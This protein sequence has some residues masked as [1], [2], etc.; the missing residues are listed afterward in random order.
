MSPPCLFLITS[1]PG[2]TA[3]QLWRSCRCLLLLGVFGGSVWVT[4]LVERSS[5]S[6]SYPLM[7]WQAPLLYPL[8]IIMGIQAFPLCL[9]IFQGFWGIPFLF[10]LLHLYF[11][12]LMSGSYP[13]VLQVSSFCSDILFLAVTFIDAVVA[14]RVIQ[15]ILIGGVTLM[16]VTTFQSLSFFS[17]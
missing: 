7:S 16:R 3:I 9:L 2:R 10:L 6:A 12:W 13:L 5:S 14:A 11:G 8:M 4:T 1:S 15:A 17:V